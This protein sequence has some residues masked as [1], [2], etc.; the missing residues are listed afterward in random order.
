MHALN[1]YLTQMNTDFQLLVI[2]TPAH[3]S[4]TAQVST[5]G[6]EGMITPVDGVRSIVMFLAAWAS[7]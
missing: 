1:R 6:H 7:G 3:D 4:E 2:S 5:S